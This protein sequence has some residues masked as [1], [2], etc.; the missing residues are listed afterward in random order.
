DVQSLPPRVP[1][2]LGSE[3][4]RVRLGYR[5][6]LQ[7][8]AARQRAHGGAGELRGAR[9]RRGEKDPLRARRAPLLCRVLSL[10][11]RAVIALSATAALNVPRRRSLRWSL[12]AVLKAK[13]AVPLRARSRLGLDA[14]CHPIDG[15]S[16]QTNLP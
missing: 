9:L 13:T 8:R 5:A 11:I 15:C 1:G 7:A 16:S 6:R 2:R 12:R 3:E 4:R 14:A 10:S